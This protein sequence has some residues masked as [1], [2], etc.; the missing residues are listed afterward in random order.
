[1]FFFLIECV[2]GA[3][4]FFCPQAGEASNAMKK[5]LKDRG[6]LG[7][8]LKEEEKVR[9]LRTQGAQPNARAKC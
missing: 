9:I 7:R 6:V 8:V 3:K 1:M 5:R 4:M 2:M